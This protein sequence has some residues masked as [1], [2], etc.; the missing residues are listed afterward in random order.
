MVY[1]DQYHTG[2]T[3]K[4]RWY[5]LPSKTTYYFDQY[6]HTVKNRWDNITTNAYYFDNYGHTV[7]NRWYTLPTKRTYYFDNEGHTVKNRLYTLQGN[8][9]YYFDGFGHSV[10]PLSN[11]SFVVIGYAPG[12]GITVKRS[13]E[14]NVLHGTSR[15]LANGS[16]CKVIGKKSFSNQLFY[17]LRKL[18]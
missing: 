17:Y 6:G 13:D 7:R 8:K 10:T 12:Q 4:N 5:T 1:N 9:T 18:Q 14:N 11:N 2:H 15:F 16:L 3:V